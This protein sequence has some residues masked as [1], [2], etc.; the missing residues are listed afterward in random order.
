MPSTTTTSSTSTTTTTEVPP[1]TSTIPPLDEVEAAIIEDIEDAVLAE[2]VEEI[3][4]GEVDVETVEA[5]VSSES[6]EELSE[7]T[8]EAV[9]VALSDA[10]TE[11]KEEFEDQVNVFEG[12]FDEYVPSGSTITVEERRVVV[13]VTVTV[14]AASAAAPADGGG[15]G[16]GGGGAG[17]S[18]RRKW[19]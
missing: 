15:S 14:A 18:R 4:T 5:L 7:E 1:T 16:G 6:F 8:L 2:A 11:V 12:S 13:A 10:P 19:K 9:S 17:P 3:F